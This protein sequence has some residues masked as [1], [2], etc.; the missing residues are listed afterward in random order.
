[1]R[2]TSLHIC[3]TA[4]LPAAERDAI[5]R[6]I[7]G[8]SRNAGG[9]LIVQHLDLLIEPY[10]FGFFVHTGLVEDDP[11]RPDSVSP[12]LWEI[13]RAAAEASAAWILFDCDE[14]VTPG[15]PVF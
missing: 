5:D 15:L 4:H 13:L 6:L 12:G 7:A 11:E 8:A 1:V 9:R 14:T 2:R 10:Q 3:S